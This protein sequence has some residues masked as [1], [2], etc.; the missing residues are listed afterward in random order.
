MEDSNGIDSDRSHIKAEILSGLAHF[1]HHE[2]LF[3]QISTPTDSRVGPFYGFNGQNNAFLND[4]RLPDTQSS[5]F[6]RH[7]KSKAHILPL[8]R[9]RFPASQHPL[10][11]NDLGKEKGRFQNSDA[12]PLQ[13]LGDSPEKPIV[14]P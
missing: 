3:P 8:L 11:G 2:T 13:L 12:F 1:D 9:R 14:V 6:L 4:H 5:R 10:P 7:S